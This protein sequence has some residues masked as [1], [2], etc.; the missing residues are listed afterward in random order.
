MVLS[1]DA[2]GGSLKVFQNMT[3]SRWALNQVEPAECLVEAGRRIWIYVVRGN[4][5]LNGQTAGTSDAFAMWDEVTLSIHTDEESEI[6]LFDLPP[7]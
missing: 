5:T 4:V 3:L 1:P 6:L 2:R 7:V